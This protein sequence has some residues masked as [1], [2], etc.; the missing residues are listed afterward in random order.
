MPSAV[1]NTDD[2][3]ILLAVNRYPGLTPLHGPENDALAFKAWLVSAQ[4]GAVPET[5]VACILS[6]DYP[7][8]PDPYD[9]R[10]AVK[11]FHRALD[12]ITLDA[13]RQFKARAGRRLYL[14][15]AGH[16]FT[17]GAIKNDPALFTAEAQSFDAVHIAAP[18]YATRMADA[19]L[20]DEIVLV[21]DC[22]QDFFFTKEVMNPTWTPPAR[23]LSN[24]VRVFQAFGAPRGQAAYEDAPTLDGP[25]RGNFSRI[26]CEALA[27]AEADDEGWVTSDT[28]R[29]RVLRLWK[30]SGLQ[31]KTGNVP[32]IDL[33][34]QDIRFYRKADP[35]R[36]LI[37][38]A[39]H[40]AKNAD[41]LIPP[42][43]RTAMRAGGRALEDELSFGTAPARGLPPRTTARPPAALRHCDV[44]IEAQDEL[45]TIEVLD[46]HL[47]TVAAGVGA[48]AVK[49]QAGRY[50]AR[51]RL[52]DALLE[53]AFQVLSDPVQVRCPQRL[54]FSSP[55]PLPDT[56]TTHE[57]QSG[58]ADH[59]TQQ[60][61]L[62]QGGVGTPGQLLVFVRASQ[63]APGHVDADLDLAMKHL[64]LRDERHHEQAFDHD[65]QDEPCGWR[66]WQASPGAGGYWLSWRES[67]A[68]DARC[69]EIPVHVADGQSTQVFVDCDVRDTPRAPGEGRVRLRLAEASIASWPHALL[70]AL[71]AP[72]AR[73]LDSLRSRLA[74]PPTGDDQALADKAAALAGISPQAAVYAIG[75]CLRQ[76]RVDWRQVLDI[77]QAA[78]AQADA[79]ARPL[80]QAALRAPFARRPGP[81]DLLALIAIAEAQLGLPASLSLPLTEAPQMA[82]VWDLAEHWRTGELLDLPLCRLETHLRVSG[83]LQAA[84]MRPAAWHLPDEAELPSA[85]LLAAPEDWAALVPALKRLGPQM[86][87]LQGVIRGRII[88]QVAEHGRFDIHLLNLH[89][90]IDEVDVRHAINGLYQLVSETA[91][92]PATLALFAD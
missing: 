26:W 78:L 50:T 65:A 87:P 2:H 52:G 12:R 56:A 62:S 14:F 18:R 85:T 82:F 91:P 43:G 68:P 30:D 40:P 59:L 25:V 22:C 31:D 57:Y 88:A 76:A 8:P 6:S 11:D 45:A 19:G 10:P 24:Q 86:T 47:H 73:L 51:F 29:R 32:P 5:Q 60:C 23:N 27:S 92:P 70:P 53:E 44:H 21:M 69:V 90:R 66:F 4:G 63:H 55:V 83:G 9:E 48:L 17:A 38:I 77:A 15:L 20:F 16:G 61:R 3:A 33:P 80:S 58:P 71:Q 89:G 67:L 54:H 34:S 75:L 49:L 36:D 28:V 72:Q 64:T 41:P 84:F 46:K 13:Q 79:Q 74:S 7:A 81:P 37:T 39:P 35:L 1:L 42:V